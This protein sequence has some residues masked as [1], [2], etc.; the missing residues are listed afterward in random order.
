[1]A[2]RREAWGVYSKALAVSAGVYAANWIA[3]KAFEAV[4]HDRV[5]CWAGAFAAVQTGILL[6]LSLSLLG[7]RTYA[8]LKDGL[9]EQISP[10]IRDR[11]L[12]LAFEGESWTSSVPRHGPARRV[13]ER[14]IAHTLKTVKADGRDRVA[15]FAIEAG[16]AA[17]WE[18]ACYARSQ[19]ERKRA[20]CLLGLIAPV[21]GNTHILVALSDEYAEVRGDAYRALLASGDSA[22]AG[23]VFRSVLKEPLLLRA[24]LADDL[25]R[26]AAT[27]WEQTIPAV[28][29]E[30]RDEETARC[31]EMLIAWKRA[32][33]S[34]DIAPWLAE[35][36]NPS[37]QQLALALAPYVWTD[38][39]VEERVAA[40]LQSGSLDVRCA[41]TQ[42]VGR[43]KLERLIPQL[44]SALAGEKQLAVAAGAA[45]AELGALGEA[46]LGRTVVGHQRKAAAVA[47][48]A[49]EHATVRRA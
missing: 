37:L 45:L 6:L 10:A 39:A 34:F 44:E 9:Y 13:L 22:E 1:M 42:A 19:R 29:A 31:L 35:G 33:P 17:E 15:R 40:A 46:S 23:R 28:L 48:E 14:T 49:L 24:L 16:F 4:F 8:R 32:L 7:A 20:I 30:A 26:H 5:L 27:L 43:L 47:M 21:A 2:S 25:K 18:E 11:V 38:E 36:R 41:A 12:A 3:A